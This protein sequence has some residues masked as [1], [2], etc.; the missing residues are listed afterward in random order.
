MIFLM[1][2]VYFES[3][4]LSSTLAAFGWRVLKKT[5]FLFLLLS[6]KVKGLLTQGMYV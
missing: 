4:G 3:R 5:I 6:Y 1:L 2:E